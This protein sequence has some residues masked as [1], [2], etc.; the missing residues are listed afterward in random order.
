MFAGLH[1]KHGE[2]QLMQ[3]FPESI[4]G[5]EQE[6]QFVDSLSHSEHDSSQIMQELD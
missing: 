2:V 6:V 5:R 4:K 1:S 3:L